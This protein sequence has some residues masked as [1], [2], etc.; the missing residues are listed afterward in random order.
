M[1]ILWIRAVPTVQC[2][3]DDNLCIMVLNGIEINMS[4]S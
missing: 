4:F 3:T 1:N 2:K